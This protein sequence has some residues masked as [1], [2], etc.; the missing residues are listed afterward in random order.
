MHLKE[1]SFPSRQRG[2]PQSSGWTKFLYLLSES[3]III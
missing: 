2:D 1:P 3:I